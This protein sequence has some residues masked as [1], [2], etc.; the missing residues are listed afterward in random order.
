MPKSEFRIRGKEPVQSCG[1]TH[2][3][4]AVGIIG[5][6]GPFILDMT[7]VTVI[8][9]KQNIFFS[10]MPFRGNMKNKSHYDAYNAQKG[11]FHKI[12]QVLCN[13]T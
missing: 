12:E 3:F 10:L 9:Q 5:A 7:L 4:W 2:V 8:L 6:V 13:F 1:S 11:Y